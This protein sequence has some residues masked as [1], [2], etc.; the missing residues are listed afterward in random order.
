MSIARKC[1]IDGCSNKHLARG[2]CNKH[3]SSYKNHGDPLARDKAKELNR[4]GCTV[5]NCGVKIIAR[6]LCSKHYDR[7]RHRGGDL[8]TTLV[9]EMGTHKSCTIENCK[10]K[11]T[12]SSRSGVETFNRGYCNKHYSK[13]MK[14]GDPLVVKR[15]LH[16]GYNS[17]EYTSWTGMKQRCYNRNNTKYVHY[18]GRGIKVCDRWLNNFDNFIKDMGRKP[19]PEHSIDRIDVNGNYAPENCRWATH[20]EQALN[21]RPRKKKQ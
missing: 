7:W 9:T 13:L 8:S 16:G 3:Y 2:W 18:G 19:T 20:R 4:R 10:E 11:G 6:G 17:P 15:I 1:T 12:V 14:Y 5:G 21:K